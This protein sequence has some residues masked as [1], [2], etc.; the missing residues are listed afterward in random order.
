MEPLAGIEPVT[1]SLRM[2]CST[3]WA[4]SASEKNGVIQQCQWNTDLILLIGGWLE[5]D[6]YLRVKNP[7]NDCGFD[8]IVFGGSELHVSDAELFWGE[9]GTEKAFVETG[10][11]LEKKGISNSIRANNVI[12]ITAVGGVVAFDAKSA[13]WGALWSEEEIAIDARIA[14]EK[15]FRVKA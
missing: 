2:S 1:C 11:V 8:M 4:T 7:V 3:N 14:V 12:T 6:K 5:R 13:G 15:I 10:A 9:V